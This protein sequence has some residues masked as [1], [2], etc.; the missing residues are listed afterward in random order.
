MGRK[1]E[2]LKLISERSGLPIVAGGGFYAQ[3]F[4]PA[5]NRDLSEDQ[6]V[7]DLVKRAKPQP[8]GAFGEIGTWT[9]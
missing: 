5:R 9:K 7:D 4:L 2:S 6:I 1:L 8:I 3:P